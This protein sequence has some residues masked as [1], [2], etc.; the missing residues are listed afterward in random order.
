MQRSRAGEE[1]LLWKYVRSYL[2]VYLPK[3]RGLSLNTISSYRQSIS[4][5]CLFLKEDRRIGF[6]KA[7]FDH[8]TRE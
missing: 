4:L 1:Q 3:I 5:Y 6:S 8:V 2:T 7:S